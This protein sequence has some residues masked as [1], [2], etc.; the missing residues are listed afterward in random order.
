[1]QPKSQGNQQ[2]IMQYLKDWKLLLGWKGQR[3]ELE[4]LTE[5]RV[6]QLILGEHGIHELGEYGLRSHYLPSSVSCG[7][8]MLESTEIPRTMRESIGAIWT[9]QLWLAQGQEKGGE[10]NR[11]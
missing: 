11:R 8:F 4:R 1:M 2:E 6:L 5:R 3:E 7:Y 10:A 9:G